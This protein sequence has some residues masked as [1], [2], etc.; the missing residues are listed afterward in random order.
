M[1]LTVW[2]FVSKLMPLLF[3]TLSSLVIVFL[4]RSKCLNFMA[5]VII[6]SDFGAQENKIRHCFQF[7][8]STCHEVTGLDALILVF[9]MLIFKSA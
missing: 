5:A 1:A 8:P 3:N 2:T 9:L 7:F 6:H 4:P